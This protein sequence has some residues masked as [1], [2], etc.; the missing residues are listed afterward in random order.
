MAT[1][2]EAS[3]SWLIVYRRGDGVHRLE[4]LMLIWLNATSVQ[5]PEARVKTKMLHACLIAIGLGLCTDCVFAS[6]FCNLAFLF[7]SCTILG[8]PN[9]LHRMLGGWLQVWDVGHGGVYDPRFVCVG[10]G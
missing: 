7:A 4:I 8:L 1:H 2:G 3:T 6:Y 10:V 9:W 5:Y